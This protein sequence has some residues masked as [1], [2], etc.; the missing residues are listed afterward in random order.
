[1][2][3]EKKKER[4]IKKI[5]KLQSMLAFDFM[6]HRDLSNSQQSNTVTK[7]VFDLVIRRDLVHLE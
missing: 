4:K 6:T 2:E 5:N 1:M 7:L 3:G